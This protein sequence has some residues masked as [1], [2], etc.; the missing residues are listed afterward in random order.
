M[1]TDD[2]IE[3]Y[4]DYENI[5]DPYYI[6]LYVDDY[7]IF[8]KSDLEKIAKYLS[9]YF[10]KNGPDANDNFLHYQSCFM[11]YDTA[12]KS[13]LYAFEKSNIK[14]LSFASFIISCHSAECDTRESDPVTGKLLLSYP[15]DI[16]SVLEELKYLNE[17]DRLSED[18]WNYLYLVSTN[19]N[20]YSKNRKEKIFS[21]FFKSLA[22]KFHKIEQIK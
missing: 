22:E 18:D 2:I 4:Y 5:E 16:E 14:K 10:E 21:I 15:S 20:N 8:K 1:S 3:L 11:S 17:Y 12:K 19:M 13:L 7:D 9:E 6:D